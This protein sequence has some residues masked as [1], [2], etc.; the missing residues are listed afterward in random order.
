VE[1]EMVLKP[2][3]IL[4]DVFLPPPGQGV[5]SSYRKVRARQSWDF[6]LAGLAL[7][8]RFNQKQ[9]EQARVVLSGAAP[10]PWRSVAVEEA[11]TGKEIN[12]ET[13]A[14][15]AEAVVKNAEP[16][17]HN[18]YKLALFRGIMEEELMAIAR[19]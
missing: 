4:T 14:K 6:A 15:A 11:I 12:A 19:S 17:K 7:V 2:N 16:L 13:V 10:V 1:K 18:G 3:E 8:L 9:V 5:R